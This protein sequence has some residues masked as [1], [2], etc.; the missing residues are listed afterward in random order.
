MKRLFVGTFLTREQQHLLTRLQERK[1][2]LAALWRHKL[3]WVKA[4]KLHMTW[5]FIGSQPADRVE[6]IS[7]CLSTAVQGGPGG[8]ITYDRIEFWPAPRSPRQLVMTAQP[9]LEHFVELCRSIRKSLA[10]YAEKE[11]TRAFRPHVTLLRFERTETTEKRTL[12]FP[13]WF[14]ADSVLP[15]V[16]TIDRVDLIESHMGGGPEGYEVLRSFA[17]K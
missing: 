9:V 17:L 13:E 14:D 15:M 5:F 8:K 4:D 3:R 16:H 7:S 1:E 2:D 12:T 10:E 11:E 6:E